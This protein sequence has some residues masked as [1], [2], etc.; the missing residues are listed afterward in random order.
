MAEKMKEQKVTR[1]IMV[2]AQSLTPFAKNALQDMQ[3]RYH[4]EQFLENELLVNI[5]EHVLVP[6]HRILTPEEKKT[7]LERYKIKETQLP[8]IQVCT[9]ANTV[10]QYSLQPSFTL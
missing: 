9:R 7:L 3:P 5:T 2:A 8:R 1:A 10:C 6:P 4:I